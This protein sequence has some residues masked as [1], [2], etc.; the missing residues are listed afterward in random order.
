MAYERSR[1][2]ARTGLS[3]P[4]GLM[5][6]VCACQDDAVDTTASKAD[7]ASARETKEADEAKS[8]AEEISAEEASAE[9]AADAADAKA[10]ES[11]IEK[12]A[13]DECDLET[14]YAGDEFCILPPPA[15]KGFQLHI[16]PEDYANPDAKYLLQ[17]GEE[18]TSNFSATSTNDEKVFFYFR[19][20]RMRPGAHHNII[21]TRGASDA[22]GTDGGRRIGTVNALVEDNPK[23]NIIAP[24][25]Q[26]VG[27]PLEAHSDINVSLHSI[28]STDKPLLREIW[29]NFWYRDPSEVT[30]PTEELFQAGGR[31][32]TRFAIGPREDTVLGP[33]RCNI[34]GDGRMLWFYGHRH[35]NNVRFSAWRI[36]G[37]QKDLFYEAYDWEETLVLEYA[38]TVENPMADRETQIEGGW[39][40]I[41]DVKQGDQLEWECHVIN[42]TDGTL[43]FTN[44]TFTGEMCIMDAEL[45]GANCR[46]EAGAAPEADPAD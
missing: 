39:S 23:G 27:I 28:N 3:F 5:L 11:T 44:N 24:E 2:L 10:D 41:L 22:A 33:F 13:M 6:V 8:E 42:K 25:N 7:K 17:P 46:G 35:A 9:G 31:E 29:V 40:G 26:G 30:E 32:G 19:Q 12:P 21:T 43:R 37:D 20:F 16:G 45:V 1:T 36:R 18:V 4:L 14:S 38:S 34:E 15:D